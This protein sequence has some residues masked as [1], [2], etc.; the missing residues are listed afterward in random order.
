MGF[1]LC[2]FLDLLRYGVCMSE[3]KLTDR[4]MRDPALLYAFLENDINELAMCAVTMNEYLVD[5]DQYDTA[6][7]RVSKI[8]EAATQQFLGSVRAAEI[9]A[10]MEQEERDY[11]RDEEADYQRELQRDRA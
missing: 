2:R 11:R 1:G 4:F 7:A 3:T 9:R 8:V 10:E 5:S 6:T